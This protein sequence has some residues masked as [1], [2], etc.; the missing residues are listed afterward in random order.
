MDNE[1]LNI[2]VDKSYVV[3]RC[4]VQVYTYVRILVHLNITTS[5]YYITF[6][7]KQQ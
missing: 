1:R 6:F 5:T 7:L 3:G 4:K 2:R